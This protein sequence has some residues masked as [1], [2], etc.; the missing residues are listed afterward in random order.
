VMLVTLLITYLPMFAVLALTGGFA[1]L[2]NPGAL[3]SPTQFITQQ[4]LA[5][6]VGVLTG[7]FMIAVIV[8]LYFD[9][10]VRTE[11]LDVQM[12]TDRLA[13]AGD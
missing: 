10:R 13:V 2:A 1:Q 4:V 5:M 11:A 12:M 9:R 8:L 6:G 7:P 3:P